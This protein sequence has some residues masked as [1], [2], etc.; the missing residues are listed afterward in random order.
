[1][2]HAL[3]AARTHDGVV[4]ELTGSGALGYVRDA[5]EIENDLGLNMIDAGW[6]FPP[7]ALDRLAEDWDRL[8]RE[9]AAVSDEDRRIFVLEVNRKLGMHAVK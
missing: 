6:A 3:R 1:L 2:S 8:D 4:K 5:L 9:L 7:K